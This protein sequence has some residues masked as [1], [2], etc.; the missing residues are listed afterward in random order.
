[1]NRRQFL[2]RFFQGVQTYYTC[3]YG[4]GAYHNWPQKNFVPINISINTVYRASETSEYGLN[5]D[6]RRDMIFA[7][8]NSQGE[9][10]KCSSYYNGD[11]LV[12]TF[13]DSGCGVSNVPGGTYT[14]RCLQVGKGLKLVSSSSQTITLNPSRETSP[15]N[16]YG[17]INSETV[18]VKFVFD[19]V[20]ISFGADVKY[21]SVGYYYP[22]NAERMT[23]SPP[24]FAECKAAHD[25]EYPN[26]TD[27]YTQ[28]NYNDTLK[29]KVTPPIDGTYN[30]K[31]GPVYQI[32]PVL[33]IYEHTGLNNN[34]E[35]DEIDLTGFN[36]N[37][38]YD[39]YNVCVK[40]NIE[41]GQDV[42]E[43]VMSSYYTSYNTLDGGIG[44]YSTLERFYWSTYGLNNYDYTIRGYIGNSTGWVGAALEGFHINP[45]VSDVTAGSIQKVPRFSING[46]TLSGSIM[47][48]VRIGYKVDWD[49]L[50][51]GDNE[52]SYPRES[53][54]RTVDGN[55]TSEYANSNLKLVKQH[56][57]SLY[58]D[59]ISTAMQN[60][61]KNPGGKTW[62]VSV[63]DS[64]YRQTGSL[65]I[66]MDAVFGHAPANSSLYKKHV[67]T[68]DVTIL[69]NSVGSVDWR[70]ESY[71][72][73]FYDTLSGYCGNLVEYDPDHK[74]NDSNQWL[75]VYGSDNSSV[76]V[77][78]KQTPT[79]IDLDS[80]PDHKIG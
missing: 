45:V 36:T 23:L 78:M 16:N 35:I 17:Y 28:D 7:I 67:P 77:F 73:E 4:F 61:G 65:D 30:Y 41:Y 64:R 56:R 54:E 14:V 29:G 47:R 22:A 52:L 70:Y 74:C 49:V 6:M 57:D 60:Y 12:N 26:Y 32:A 3:K 24:T 2:G 31:M 50:M 27:D 10:I 75:T 15:Y 58:N 53:L 20:G 66:P 19:V 44:D 8:Y 76:Q 71:R 1:M 25:A 46:K 18:Y 34:A 59:C 48:M 69:V 37:G 38:S 13:I 80:V 40:N 63:G 39:L 55:T 9:L 42:Y 51:Y 11:T 5:N 68:S 72:E 43:S 62:W 21:R 33:K 79:P